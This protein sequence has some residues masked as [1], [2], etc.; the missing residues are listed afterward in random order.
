MRA[1]A[2][3]SNDHSGERVDG[4]RLRYRDLR[5]EIL[6][7]V[8][9]HL[10]EHGISGM[11]FRTL[12]VA[13][14]VSHITL[15]H[16]FGTKDE[17]L[18][19]IFGVIGARV[20]I[21]DHFGADDVESLVRKMWQRWTEPQSDRRSRLV[22]EAYAHAVR[23]PDE[24]R[25]FLDRVVTGWI[26]IIRYHALLAGCPSDEADTFATLLLAQLRGLQFDFLAT[27]DRVRI[28]TALESVIDGI[29]HQRAQ[30]ARVASR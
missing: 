1:M 26:E 19:E 27:G 16:H 10:L 29:H 3:V 20:Q 17:L 4:R 12:A 23:S 21:P 30:W 5:G 24:Y 2:M 8:M 7:A 13:A 9:A 6:D 18:V 11:S 25:A 15:R 22:F 28:G 14:G